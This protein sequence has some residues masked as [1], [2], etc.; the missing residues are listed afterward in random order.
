MAEQT[1]RDPWLIAVWPGMGNVAVGAG[2]HLV[3]A[4][5]MEPA[6]EIQARGHFD[7]QQIEVERGIAKPPRMPRSL[8]YR[9][10]N[11]EGGRDLVV[12]VG[13][14][15]PAQGSYPFCH[16]LLEAAAPFGVKRVVTFASMA[17][18]LHPSQD[19]RVFGVATS[20]DVLAEL[21][22]LD[23]EPLR[24]G[25]IGGL[26][27]VLLGAGYERDLPGMSLLG[28]I[29]FF[30]AGV[31]N[32]K[33]SMAVLEAFSALTGIEVDLEPLR[34]QAVAVDDALM[35]L[36]ERMKG[37][38]GAEDEDE[39]PFAASA[40]DKPETGA[41]PDDDQP[42]IDPATRAQIESLFQEAERDRA[43]AFRLKEELDRLGVFKQF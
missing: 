5:N 27:G 43:K 8:F 18:Q 12:F 7:V 14:A 20:E 19:P 10:R 15:Q 26:N 39:S 11:P 9:W 22:G 28:E 41:E 30:A 23:V 6:G 16:Q 37:E 24:E 42:S 32:P 34:E 4:L 13:E 1:L 2:L 21:E 40:F 31:P 25:Q 17:S 36:L 38:M 33:A 3:N 35:Q 29:P